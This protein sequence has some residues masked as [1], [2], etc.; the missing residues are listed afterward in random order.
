MKKLLAAIFILVV[1]LTLSVSA[2]AAETVMVTQTPAAVP[3]FLS[4]PEKEVDSFETY[5]IPIPAG[6][7]EVI[8]PL[9]VTQKGE[10]YLPCY[11]QAPEDRY[12]DLYSDAACTI[13]VDS[14]YRYIDPNEEKQ[15]SFAISQA[16]TYYLKISLRYSYNVSTYEGVIYIAPCLASSENRK[17][18]S[19]KYTVGA[20]SASGR[21][22]Y[23]EISI[24]E[25]GYIGIQQ[26]NAGKSS[27]RV[28]LCD[29]SKSTIDYNYVYGDNY[30]YPVKKGTYYL[31]TEGVSS[32]NAYYYRLRYT[33]YKQSSSTFTMTDNKEKKIN[34]F[35]KGDYYLRV[36]AEKTG[37][38]TL[39]HTGAYGLYA[40]LCNSSKT[41]LSERE[42]MSSSSSYATRSFAVTKDKTYYFKVNGN[43][44]NTIS[45]KYK[46]TGVTTTKNTTKAKATTLKKNTAAKFNFVAGESKTS[47]WY[48]FTQSGGKKLNLDF[49]YAGTG[50]CSVVLYKGTS[51]ITSTSVNSSYSSLYTTG[52]L[53]SGTYYLQF[54]PKDKLSTGTVTIKLKS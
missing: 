38:L 53:S 41:P 14:G 9:K 25:D 2:L 23:Y 39:Y 19:G 3:V 28:D 36:K 31:K 10:L 46:I 8:Y 34:Q 27:F 43:I 35:G 32:Y 44:D 45:L 52:T 5:T 6:D 37:T 20:P 49:K 7:V 48:K 4:D 29:K 18:T 11:S 40:T 51:K 30:Y 24:P 22:T 1:V 21:V 12:L 47:Y 17:L 54:T 42:W 26:T 33:F 16:G 15:F 13:P 50:Y